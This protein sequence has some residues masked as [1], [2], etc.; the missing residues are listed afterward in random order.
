MQNLLIPHD[1]LNPWKFVLLLPSTRQDGCKKG[2]LLAWLL[3]NLGLIDY[4]KDGN[5]VG[6]EIL[7]ASKRMDNPLAVDYVVMG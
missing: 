6:M 7:D 1:F 4:D 5:V 2:K 3:H